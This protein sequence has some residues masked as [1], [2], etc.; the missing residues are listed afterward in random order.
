MVKQYFKDDSKAHLIH[1]LSLKICHP[2]LPVT[3]C[4]KTDLQFIFASR[5]QSQN[6]LIWKKQ[7]SSHSRYILDVLL[8]SPMAI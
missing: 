3:Q 1:F 2:V 7:N 6:Q 5:G 4:M 8:L